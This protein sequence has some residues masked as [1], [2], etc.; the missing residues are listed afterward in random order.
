MLDV[1]GSLIMT[2]KVENTTERVKWDEQVE[3]YEDEIDELETNHQRA[4]KTLA[5]E[6]KKQLKTLQ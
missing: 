4:M 5:T 3:D 6:Y 1:L 2:G